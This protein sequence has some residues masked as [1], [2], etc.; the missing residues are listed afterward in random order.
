MHYICTHSHTRTHVHTH[1]EDAV[2]QLFM[3]PVRIPKVFQMLPMFMSMPPTTTS[4][5]GELDAEHKEEASSVE[6]A[7]G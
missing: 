1:R 5:D 7:R 6:D 2:R 4:Q 3:G